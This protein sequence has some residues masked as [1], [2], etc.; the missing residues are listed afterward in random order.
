MDDTGDSSLWELLSTGGQEAVAAENQTGETLGVVVVVTESGCEI[1]LSYD[2]GAITGVE[3]AALLQL[4]TEELVAL[5]ASMGRLE[6][7]L[8]YDGFDE[9]GLDDFLDGL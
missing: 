7:N 9:D 5:A 6:K 8:D 1:G 4:Y 3:A 2:D